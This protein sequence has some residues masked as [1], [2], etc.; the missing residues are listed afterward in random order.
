MR[1]RKPLFT[2]DEFKAEMKKKYRA[3]YREGKSWN[4]DWRP[5]G[6]FTCCDQ[7]ISINKEWLRGFDN[8]LAK[9]QA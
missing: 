9:Q 2:E 7:T 4:R 8:G 6:P 3:G 1:D 5:G